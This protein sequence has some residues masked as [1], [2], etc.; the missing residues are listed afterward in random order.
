MEIG[1]YLRQQRKEKKMTQKALSEATGI[2]EI[3]IR[4]YE[5]G[6]YKPKWD[7]LVKIAEALDINAFSIL[8]EVESEDSKQQVE[9]P[10]QWQKTTNEERE[11][12]QALEDRRLLDKFHS[13]PEDQ[14]WSITTIIDALHKNK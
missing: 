11:M 1:K 5:A 10:G 12:L 9:L 4:Q 13:L 14:Q 2:A 8:N 3:T 7:N 6:K